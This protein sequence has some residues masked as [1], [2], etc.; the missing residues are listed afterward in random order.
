MNDVMQWWSD[1]QG[2]SW[3]APEGPGSSIEGLDDS[4]VVQVSHEDA[5]AFAAWAGGRLPTEAEWEFAAR[6][7]P[8]GTEIAWGDTYDP[9]A[10]WK[11]N[12][13][14]GAFPVA[15]SADDGFYGVAPVASYQPDAYGLYDMAGNV[16]ELVADWYVPMHPERAQNP[17]RVEGEER[18]PEF[19]PP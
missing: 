5:E 16:W 19:P 18:V 2:A 12:T 1:V 9:A 17:E 13:W 4:P 6:G 8:D 14:Q 15:D 11:A 3:R 7:G 10:G